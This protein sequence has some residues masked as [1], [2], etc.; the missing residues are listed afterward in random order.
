M[1]WAGYDFH[2]YV[3]INY[4]REIRKKIKQYRIWE[5]ELQHRIFR[6]FSE[7]L[8]YLIVM[9]QYDL[10]KV[11]YNRLFDDQHLFFLWFTFQTILIK[12][13]AS[14]I[15]INSEQSYHAISYGKKHRKILHHASESYFG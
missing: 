14:L 8:L 10:E 15:E 12:I 2:N 3:E 6:L 5:N 7:T 1:S 9:M 13:I 11:R 4:L